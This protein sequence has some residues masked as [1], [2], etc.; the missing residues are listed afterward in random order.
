VNLELS[1]DQEFFRETTRRFLESEA[2][3][4]VARE[5]WDVPEGF[6]REWWRKAAELGW[7]SMFVPE[8]HGGGSVSGHPTVDAV[9]VAEEMGR[10]VA[11]GPFLPVNVVAAA[12]AAQGSEAQQAGLLPGLLAGE[13]VASWAFAEPGGAWNGDGVHLGAQVDGDAVVL[14]GAKA[15]VEAAGVADTF[16]VTAR[17]GDALTQVL[18]PAT[19]GGLTVTRGRSIDLTRRYGSLAFDGVRLPLDAVVGEVGGADDQVARQLILALALQNAETVGA[20]DRV[21]EIT[22][23]YAQD[24]FAFGR[25]IASFQALKHR[26]ADMLMW[27][28]F[29][30]AIADGS[31]RAIDADDPEAPRLVSVAAAYVGD[32]C[33]DLIDDCVQ[34]SGGIGV[35]WE[36]DVHLY[37]RRVA[38]N[39]AV[40]GSPEEHKERVAVLL[41][42]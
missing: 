4:T 32:R 20:A 25:P 6:D 21:F 31:A 13:T 36:H 11:P 7:T 17:T 14:T 39:R 34:I 41:G 18:V 29:S 2:P 10:L 16:L 1:E 30:K 15:Y 23:E 38:V 35:T 27:L 42:A 22:T 9:I 12:V 40:Y 3:L 8:A 33:L 24:R 28:E 37:S 19:T 5:L 26:I